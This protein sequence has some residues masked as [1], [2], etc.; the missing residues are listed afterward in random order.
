MKERIKLKQTF[1][2]AWGNRW[3]CSTAID[4]LGVIAN[5]TVQR[6]GHL[7]TKKD[8]KTVKAIM[9]ERIRRN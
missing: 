2:S 4:S 5:V 3:T 8:L 7:K 9:L 1:H 6:N